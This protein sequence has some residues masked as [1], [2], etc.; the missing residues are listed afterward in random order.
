MQIDP[1]INKLLLKFIY[2]LYE[3]KTAF[4]VG[5][6]KETV[7]ERLCN[8]ERKFAKETDGV[9]GIIKKRHHTFNIFD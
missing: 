4:S 6:G 3:P 7:N 8:L 1:P 2:S 5:A 9:D